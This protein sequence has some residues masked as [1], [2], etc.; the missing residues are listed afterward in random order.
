M[1]L[2]RSR[3][4]YAYHS[5]TRTSE[6]PILTTEQQDD[7]STAILKKKKK[8][9]QLMYVSCAV[10]LDDSHGADIFPLQGYGRY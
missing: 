1:F 3:K 10:L 7:T 8:P 4:R 5:L 9:N 6:R 2:A